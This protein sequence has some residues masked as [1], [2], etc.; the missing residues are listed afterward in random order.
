MVTTEVS[1]LGASLRHESIQ[2]KPAFAF[3][4]CSC[5]THLLFRL[6]CCC[7]FQK[8]QC[9][10]TL[11][12]AAHHLGSPHPKVYQPI[13][14]GRSTKVGYLETECRKLR[15]QICSGYCWT[16]ASIS[17]HTILGAFE[18]N[19]APCNDSCFNSFGLFYPV[20]A[21]PSLL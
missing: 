20:F 3:H 1:P 9:Q 4:C 7:V 15:F 11:S 13:T 6:L 18:I 21:G 12:D 14:T 2:Q 16:F 10:L 17:C 5:W 8:I 19:C